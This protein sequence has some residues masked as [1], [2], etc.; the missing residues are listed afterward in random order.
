MDPAPPAPSPKPFGPLRGLLWP[1]HRHELK[2]L[3]PML[4]LFFFISFVYSILRNTK[5]TLVVTAP[6]GGASLIPFLKVY[7]VFPMAVGFMLGYAKLSN[8]LSNDPPAEPEAFR[9]WPLK[10]A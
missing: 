1:I 2:K 8:I 6:G 9:R 7:G 4:L 5:D 10:G 3:L